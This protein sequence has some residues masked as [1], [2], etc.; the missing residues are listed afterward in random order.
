MNPAALLSLLQKSF[1]VARQRAPSATSLQEEHRSR[2]R[3]WVASVASAFRDVY[4]ADPDV[5]VLWQQDDTHR[6]Q[7][8]RNELL[9]DITVVR[10]RTVPAPRQRKTLSY[11]SQVLW[12]VESEFARDGREA[13]FDFNKLVL[14]SASYKLF[15]APD[16]SKVQ[17]F[18]ETLL[19]AARVCT[20]TVFLS[21]VPHP[22]RWAEPEAS[23]RLWR[24]ELD[25]W[26]RHEVVAFQ[27]GAAT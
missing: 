1:R 13:L 21:M 18:I 24:L 9:H 10:H 11:I 2:S 3:A 26:A 19:P 6:G 15:I 23:V 8:G 12:Q 17:P 20:G 27:E 25:Q 4:S 16:V 7:F 22:A 5:A 14:G